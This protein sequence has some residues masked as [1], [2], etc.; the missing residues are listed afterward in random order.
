M[1]T[2]NKLKTKGIKAIEKE[3]A[4]KEEAII[5]F[6]GKPRY[7]IL[8]IEKYEQIRA[9]ELDLLYL[10]AQEEIKQGKAKAIHTKEELE[11]HIESL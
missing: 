11:R 3:L 8:D 1:I 7:I 10:Q 5:T 9:M 6:R 2:A 4:Q